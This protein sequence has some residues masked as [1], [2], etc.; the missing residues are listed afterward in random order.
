MATQL[1]VVACSTVLHGVSTQ[2]CG[3]QYGT[4]TRWLGRDC[5]GA[6][7]LQQSFA[8]AS[9]LPT[10]PV[11]P[12]LWTRTTVG[13]CHMHHKQIAAALSTAGG[14][15]PH[16]SSRRKP[17]RRL[18]Q[19]HKAIELALQTMCIRVPLPSQP[20][21]AGVSSIPAE[22]GQKVISNDIDNPD[23]LDFTP[24][25]A[26]HRRRSDPTIVPGVALAT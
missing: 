24:P 5:D 14:R 22:D 20:V 23:V 18:L 15:G 4:V 19:Q 3:A 1:S 8:T 7:H 10:A 9:Q 25:V 16:H 11:A 6:T 26:K 21:L 17:R 2:A 13:C 12:T